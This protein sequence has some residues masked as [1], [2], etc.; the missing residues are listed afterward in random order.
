L[1]AANVYDIDKVC[2]THQKI[3]YTIDLKTL[4][5]T[6]EKKKS[7]RKVRKATENEFVDVKKEELDEECED[8]SVEGVSGGEEEENKTTRKKQPARSTSKSK[9]KDSIK[10]ERKTKA[11]T[12]AAVVNGDE[13][14]TVRSI[15]FKGKAPVDPECFNKDKYHV[16]FEKDTVYDAMLNQTNL[17]NNN[18]KFYLMQVLQSNTNTAYAVW[19]RWGRVGMT[20]QTNFVNCGTDLAKAKETFLNKYVFKASIQYNAWSY[21][22]S[23]VIWEHMMMLGNISY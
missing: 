21:S 17:K 4:V 22:T 15:S 14:E 8:E 7:K 20:G 9:S 13:K 3:N 2:Y 12:T 5:E 11:K 1:Y 19:L 18:N 10:E 23:M 6:N 16:Y